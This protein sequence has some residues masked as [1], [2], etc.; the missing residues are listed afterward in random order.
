MVKRDDRGCGRRRRSRPRQ[1][2]LGARGR[3]Q[4]RRG[5]RV[6]VRGRRV[7]TPRPRRGA[8]IVGPRRRLGAIGTA[9][10][11]QRWAASYR[12]ATPP[13]RSWQHAAPISK[14]ATTETTASEIAWWKASSTRSRV[15]VWWKSR[16][17]VHAPIP[18]CV[19]S[20]RIY[21]I[22]RPPSCASTSSAEVRS[23][24]TPAT[25]TTNDASRRSTRSAR[26]NSTE[27]EALPLTLSFANGE[28][29][30]GLVGAAA[31]GA[32]AEGVDGVAANYLAT[33]GGAP[34]AA[35]ADERTSASG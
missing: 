21:R 10:N 31:D 3:S 1:V 20:G 2:R 33:A 26:K 8:G 27:A 34:P 16:E 11:P 15:A 32:A 29:T 24:S 7:K 35:P 5:A 28:D 25:T 30:G 18:R 22:I 23:R 9:D 13:R 14:T 12:A 4:R 6:I 17:N 19:S